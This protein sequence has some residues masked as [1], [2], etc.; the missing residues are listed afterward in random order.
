MSPDGSKFA[1]GT[2]VGGILETFKIDNKIEPQIL[3]GYYKPY[4]LRDKNEIIYTPKTQF[5]FYYLTS[6]NNYL[7][8]LSFNGGN[9]EEYPLCEMQVFDWEGNPIKKYKTNKPLLNVCID[10]E[11]GK[12]YALSQTPMKEL[13]L[14]TFNL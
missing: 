5:G 2:R 13:Y 7:Y 8:A 3:K 11:R 12:V 1:E 4:F 9:C 14:I 10:E 6:S